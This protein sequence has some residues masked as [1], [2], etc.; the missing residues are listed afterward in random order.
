[1]LLFHGTRQTQPSLIYSSEEGFNLNY[2]NAGMWGKANYFAYNISYSNGYSSQLPTG[3]RQM[4]MASVIVGKE[5][6]LQ[7]DGNL[8]VPPNQP[9][10]NVPYDSVKGNTGGSDVIMVYSNKKAYPSY[11]ITYR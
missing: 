5:V 11:I 6:V 1:M 2:A 7:P 10:T 9:G 8:R 4:F 3:Q